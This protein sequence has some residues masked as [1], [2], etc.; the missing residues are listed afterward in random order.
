[1]DFQHKTNQN[2]G[3]LVASEQDMGWGLTVC[4]VGFQQVN[5]GERYPPK[6][7]P[8]AYFFYPER[9]RV[10]DEFQLVYITNGS[11]EFRSKGQPPTE[12]D[13]GTMFLLIPGEWHSYHPSEKTGWDEYFIGFRGEVMDQRLQQNFFSPDSPLLS[14]GLDEELVRIYRNAMQVAHDKR[15][16]YQQV[17]SGMASLLVGL[18]YAKSKRAG[19]RDERMKLKMDKAMIV[20]LEQ[21]EKG[22]TPEAVAEKVGLNYSCFRKMF[23]EYTGLAPLQYMQGLKLQRAKDLLR[24]T[25]YAVK[26][27]AFM[28]NF[29]NAEYFSVF[30]KKREQLTPLEYRNSSRASLPEA[31]L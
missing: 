29:D 10:L 27:I 31:P 23:R 7:H 14:V 4:S 22:I 21:V 26:E 3:Y 11:G 8:D 18:A 17:L 25:Q 2:I 16:C 13:E 5:P 24:T 19:V 28:L 20:M 9:G 15:P 6:G 1:M 30:F 12:V